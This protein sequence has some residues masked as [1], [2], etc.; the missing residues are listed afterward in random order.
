ML[1]H[2]DPS[3]WAVHLAWA[4]YFL[5]TRV[6]PVTNLSPFHCVL[7]YQPPLFNRDSPDEL[8]PR[9]E[10]LYQESRRAWQQVQQL[11]QSQA[12][13]RKS[14]AVRQ[15]RRGPS[16]RAAQLVWL[17]TK[18]LRIPGCHELTTHFIGPFQVLCRV[19]P[20]AVHLQ[21]PKIYRICPMFQVSLLNPV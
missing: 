1:C 3:S 6:S 10:D 19:G 17:S 4:E 8:V 14:Q 21:L 18:N 15:R 2:S 12:R 13:K 16:Y 7:G 9:V 5:N 11:L 20:V